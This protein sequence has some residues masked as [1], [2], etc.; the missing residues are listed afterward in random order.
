M[1]LIKEDPGVTKSNQ[2]N[3]LTLTRVHRNVPAWSPDPNDGGIVDG[4]GRMRVMLV[5]AQQQHPKETPCPGRHQIC[6]ASRNPTGG[7]PV[8]NKAIDIDR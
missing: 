7:L 1:S 6:G 3:L 5:A 4:S 2:E 8:V